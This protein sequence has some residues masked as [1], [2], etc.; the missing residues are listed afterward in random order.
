[1]YPR[2]TG[3]NPVIGSMTYTKEDC[4]GDLLFEEIFCGIVHIPNERSYWTWRGCPLDTDVVVVLA[5]ETGVVYIP[6]KGD[7][8]VGLPRTEF[9]YYFKP[10]G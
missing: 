9:L 7:R 2:N 10:R 6:E 4:N 3:S 5:H 1:M 8:T